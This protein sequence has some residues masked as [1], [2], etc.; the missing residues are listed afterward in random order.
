[1]ALGAQGAKILMPFGLMVACL[2]ASA[3]GSAR[4]ISAAGESCGDGSG[5]ADED[6]ACALQVPSNK[7]SAEDSM[8]QA[9]AAAAGIAA[10]AASLATA[11]SLVT[12]AGRGAAWAFK[13]F[14]GDR[15]GA[16]SATEIEHVAKKLGTRLSEKELK[17][18]ILEADQDNNGEVSRTEFATSLTSGEA[19]RLK[20]RRDL[21][22]KV[23][24]DRGGL[25]DLADYARALGATSGNL[26]ER[27]KK[28]IVEQ[29][30]V[31]EKD[32]KAESSFV[33][34]LG[35]DSLDTVELVMALEEE[36]GLD[37]PDDEA[38]KLT[39][40]QSAVDYVVVATD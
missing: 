30:G 27:V 5:I 11:G 37:I 26:E 14:D 22:A 2:V 25:K 39:T 13:L 34:D 10:A 31:N 3:I 36:F 33:D 24:T 6:Q 32:L 17:Q 16:I 38:E 18:A 29:L 20:R 4:D 8:M 19:S 1:M 7:R 40:V 23:L 28:I 15:S 9:A 35:A 12:R 21:V